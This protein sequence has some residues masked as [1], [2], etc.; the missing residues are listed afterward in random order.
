MSFA[1]KKRRLFPTAR[2]VIALLLREIATT[3]GRYPGGYAWAILEPVGAIAIL[4]IAFS[5]IIRSPGLGLN[6]PLFYA[7]GYLPY[8]MYSELSQKISNSIRF[9]KPLLFYPSVTFVD[10]IIARWLL[11]VVTHLSVF[12]IVVLGI[13]LIY[14]L[15]PIIDFPMIFI[16]LAMVAVL[17]LGV[18]VLNCFLFLMFPVWEQLWGI[19]N[20]PLFIVSGVFFMIDVIPEP[21]RSYLW[22][23]PLI[24]ITG[25][26]RGGVY[27]T[28]D[29]SYV[30][31]IYVFGFGLICLV[32]GLIF[33]GRYHRYLLNER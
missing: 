30:S 20:R 14:N 26:M 11:T 9:S 4:S 1:Q 25:Y 23:N 17:G 13:I 5:L 8:M 31:F 16:A 12:A 33:L 18:G 2:S 29:T 7:T 15:D 27:S 28:Y 6:F 10:S 3:Y 19:I 22:Y 21:Y 32:V 24:Q